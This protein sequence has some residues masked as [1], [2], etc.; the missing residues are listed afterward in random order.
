MFIYLKFY[1]G[2]GYSCVH[3]QI[4]GQVDSG[5]HKNIGEKNWFSFLVNKH[6]IM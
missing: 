5:K 1:S 2:H 4:K 3:E 6:V